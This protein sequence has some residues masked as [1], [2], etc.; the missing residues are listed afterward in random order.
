[1]AALSQPLC[2]PT[3]AVILVPW[4]NTVLDTV[5]DQGVVDAHVAMAKES[6]TFTR[7]WETKGKVHATVV[8][9][10]LNYSPFNPPFA[11]VSLLISPPNGAN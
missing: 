5:A 2:Q 6:S 4:V 7:S 11:T 10:R 3:F 8:H 1:M 9:G